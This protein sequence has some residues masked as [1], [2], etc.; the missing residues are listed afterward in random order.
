MKYINLENVTIGSDPEYAAI[1]SNGIPR[2]VAGFLPGTKK[3]PFD[4][5]DGVSCQVDNVG[6]ECCIPPCKSEMEFVRNMV[7][8]KV[9]TKKK[10]QELAPDYTLISASSLRYADSELQSDEARLFGCEPSY[11]VYT[12]NVSPRPTPEQ[13]GNLRSFGFHIHIGFPIE[14]GENQIEYVN[15]IIKAM[16]YQIG[17]AS[18]VIDRD[19]D[20]RSIYGNAGDLRFRMIKNIL[21]IEYR[22][23][24][25]FMHSN[26]ELIAFVYRQTLKAIDMVNI[27]IDDI[28]FIQCQEIIDNG[29]LDAALA[30]CKKRNIEIPQQYLPVTELTSIYA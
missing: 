9:R 24:G 30:F 13:V 22:T 11:C 3:K 23:L 5:E 14:E 7:I 26:T 2:S 6:A 12:A 21:V 27:G 29:D 15:A 20:R 19:T 18:I 4:L 17:V 16:D 8:A 25:G 10:L 28:N 1:D